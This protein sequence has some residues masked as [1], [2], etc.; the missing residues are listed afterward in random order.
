MTTAIPKNRRTGPN[1]IRAR[2]SSLPLPAARYF[3][4]TTGA[5]ISSPESVPGWMSSSSV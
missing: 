2:P 4:S 5:S 1:C 3:I